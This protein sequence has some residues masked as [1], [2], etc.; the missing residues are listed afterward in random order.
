MDSLSLLVRLQVSDGTSSEAA[1][2]KT[3]RREKQKPE[4]SQMTRFI[5]S[6]QLHMTVLACSIGACRT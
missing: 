3:N 6:T 4:D 2:V 1:K 5:Q